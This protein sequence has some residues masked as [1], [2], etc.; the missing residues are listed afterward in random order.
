M[1]ESGEGQ[2]S[3]GV[4]PPKQKPLQVTSEAAVPQE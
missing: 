4:S 2:V 3:F 1:N